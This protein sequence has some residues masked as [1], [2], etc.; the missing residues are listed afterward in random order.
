MVE[1][2]HMGP[3]YPVGPD[4]NHQQ[5]PYMG[6][7]HGPSL[8]PRPMALQ[9][10]PPPEAS[11][12]PSQHR[13]DGHSM[14]PMGNRYCGPEGPPQHNYHGLRPPS[15]GLSNMWTGMNQQ[16]R[17][18]GMGLQDPNMANQR[19]FSYG[20]IPPPVGHK[21]WGEA[22]GYPHPPPNVQYQMSA[23]VS[24]PQRPPVPSADSAG[25][26][27]LASM[28]ESPEMLALQQLSASS[29]P[30]QHM[31]NFQQPGPPSGIGSLPARPSQQHPPAP[32][33]QLPH[34][35][36][37]NGPDSQPSQQTDTQPKGRLDLPSSTASAW[38]QGNFANQSNRLRGSFSSRPSPPLPLRPGL[39]AFYDYFPQYVAD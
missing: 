22:A 7:M 24:S 35:A 14:H 17:P 8:G 1:G 25:R 30:P 4:P 27:R 34:P 11:M 31:V 16:D 21:P 5:H 9:P 23:A 29:G 15:M 19:N 28:L 38:A 2:H 36:R 33:V 32:E 10:G 20:G 18:T 26:T 12:Y 6:P 37:H 13:P 39:F 3:R